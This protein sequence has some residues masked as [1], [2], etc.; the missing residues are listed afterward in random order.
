MLPT[1]AQH[2]LRIAQCLVVVAVDDPD[3]VGVLSP[4]DVF[5]T[6]STYVR[7]GKPGAEGRFQDA[8]LRLVTEADRQ[9]SQR[10]I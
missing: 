2:R 6:A 9:R 5:T 3:L 7:A 4:D 8:E 1:E 10:L